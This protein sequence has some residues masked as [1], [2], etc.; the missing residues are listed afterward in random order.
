MSEV[1]AL[2]RVQLLELEII[3]H[4]KRVKAINQQIEDDEV[5]RAAEAEVEAA[6]TEYDESAKEATDMELEISAL[7]EKRQASETLLYSGEVTNPKEMQDLQMELESLSRRKDVLDDELGR[8]NAKRD[9]RRQ[10]LEESQDSL[11]E[12]QAARA[13]ENQELMDEKAALTSKV[14]KQLTRRKT[15]VKKIPSAIYKTYNSMRA[16]NA[17]RPVSVLKDDACAV[18]GIEQNSMVITA[19]NRTDDMVNCQSCGRI[20]IKL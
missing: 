16:K 17:N 7:L 20:L 9:S 6:E 19:I 5:L 1:L 2:Y 10:K 15:L 13:I 18:C 14:N 12:T 8:I 4:T 11:K 3:D